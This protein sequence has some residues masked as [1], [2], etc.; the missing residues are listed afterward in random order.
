MDLALQ[1]EITALLCFVLIVLVWIITYNTKWIINKS[2]WIWVILFLS[3]TF[4]L[5][6]AKGVWIENIDPFAYPIRMVWAMI[7]LVSMI[8]LINK[9]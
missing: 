5:W 4:L 1:G 6:S 3:A 8:L 9:K 7:W 2:L